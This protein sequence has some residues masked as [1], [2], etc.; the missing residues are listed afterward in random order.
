MA[1]TQQGNTTKAQALRQGPLK[2]PSKTKGTHFKGR[3]PWRHCGLM[4]LGF[5]NGPLTEEQLLFN[6][7]N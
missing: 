2:D 5:A 4:C 1:V 7:S 3:R 6:K